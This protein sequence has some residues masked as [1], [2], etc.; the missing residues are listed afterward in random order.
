MVRLHELQDEADQ[1]PTSPA[2]MAH[3]AEAEA[4]AETAGV[5]SEAEE[6]AQ[7]QADTQA[8]AIE[9][10]VGADVG[11]GACAEV[12]EDGAWLWG[13]VDVVAHSARC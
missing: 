6:Q 3:A 7:A 12:K 9:A 13:V 10:G 4:R 8:E 1:G 2:S 11:T 5:R